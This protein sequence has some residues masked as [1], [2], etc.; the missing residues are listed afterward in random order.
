MEC[1]GKTMFW[2]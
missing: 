2:V 1:E